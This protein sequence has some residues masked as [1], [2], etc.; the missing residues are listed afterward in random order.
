LQEFAQL[1]PSCISTFTKIVESETC[2]EWDEELV[3]ILDE[4]R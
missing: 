4:H 2:F 1:D 3:R